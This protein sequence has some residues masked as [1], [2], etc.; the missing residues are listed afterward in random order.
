MG[1]CGKSF[2][3]AYSEIEGPPCK[4]G[5]PF[6]K[7]FSIWNFLCFKHK[8]PKTIMPFVNWIMSDKWRDS[9]YRRNIDLET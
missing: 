1:V 7:G 9:P 5:G 4:S 2:Q 3:K 8:W 6:V